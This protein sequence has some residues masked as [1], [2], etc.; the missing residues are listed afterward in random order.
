MNSSQITASLRSQVKSLQELREAD[1][2]RYDTS[3]NGIPPVRPARLSHPT[4]SGPPFRCSVRGSIPG[5]RIAMCLLP[6][7]VLALLV[8]LLLLLLL[9]F[10]CSGLHQSR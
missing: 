9:L 10:L 1:K 2:T 5:Y 7:T 8:V 3:F 4:A 6:L